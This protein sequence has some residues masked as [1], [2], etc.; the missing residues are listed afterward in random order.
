MIDAS[1][2]IMF[3]TNSISTMAIQSGVFPLHNEKDT[4]LVHV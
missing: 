1:R 4:K 2:E 3:Q